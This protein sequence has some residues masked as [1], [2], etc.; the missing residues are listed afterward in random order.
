M[1]QGETIQGRNDLPVVQLRHGDGDRYSVEIYLHGATVTS[2]RHEQIERI[3]VSSLTVWNG[4]KAIRG[5]IPVVW[6][7]F[8][9]PDT[10]MAQ[11]GFLR[12]SLWNLHELVTSD[13]EASARFL[14]T[15]SPDTLKV[16][17]HPFRVLYTVTISEEGLTCSLKTINTGDAPF[18]SHALLHTYFLIPHINEVSFSGFEGLPYTD[19]TK[20]SERFLH[21]E[22]IPF[23]ITEEVD[24]VYI[25]TSTEP[26]PDITIIHTPS[27]IPIMTIHKTAQIEEPF[28]S[29]IS[30]PCDCVLWNPWSEK[31]RA[32]ADMDDEGYLQ[33]VCVEPGTVADY[34]IVQPGQALNLTQVLT[35]GPAR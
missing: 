35:P 28:C 13:T 7:Q 18:K 26:V 2:W 27:L 3:F 24:R 23:E 20:N 6:P 14:L 12:N 32:L 10:S 22:T 19:K 30:I 16:W 1:W 15:S 8:G 11:H 25:S 17:P 21:S 4:I 5:G 34:V 9:Q 33:F 31:A 29:L